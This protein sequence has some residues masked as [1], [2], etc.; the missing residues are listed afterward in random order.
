MNKNLRQKQSRRQLF[1]GFLRYTTLGLLGAASGA[2]AWK[3]RRLLREGK[4]ISK[5]ICR[6][7][8]A[9]EQCGLPAALSA[10]QVLEE[11]G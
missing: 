3:R 1:R 8:E 9:F 4:C 2:F 11:N 7:C 6:G 10:K 5:G